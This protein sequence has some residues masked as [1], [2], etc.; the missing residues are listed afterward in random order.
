VNIFHENIHRKG[1]Y[2]ILP[3]REICVVC[4]GLDFR[5]VFDRC[6]SEKEKLGF[7]LDHIENVL[8]NPNP[9]DPARS[10]D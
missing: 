5:D 7:L 3:Q 2:N 8:K 1:C 10:V 9:D 6:S 4:M